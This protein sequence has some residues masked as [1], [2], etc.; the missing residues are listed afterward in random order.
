MA[1]E[2]IVMNPDR[3]TFLNSAGQPVDV[4]LSGM[5]VDELSADGHPTFLPS[6]QALALIRARRQEEKDRA[7]ELLHQYLGTFPT[8]VVEGK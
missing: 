3:P 7:E 5:F 6:E 1:E 2:V 4:D 8:H